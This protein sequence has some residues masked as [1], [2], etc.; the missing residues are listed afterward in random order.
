MKILLIG[1]SIITLIVFETGITY[2][3]PSMVIYASGLV[4]PIGI[5]ADNSGNL[6]VAEQGTGSG[7]TSR[8]S[9]VTTEKQVYPFLIDLPSS[10]PSFEPIG[11]EH[12][13]FDINGNVLVAQGTGSDSLSNSVLVVDT[14]GFIIGGPPLTRNSI[15]SKVNIGALVDFSNPYRIVLGPNDD[16]YVSDAGANRIFRIDRNTGVPSIFSIFN[17]IGQ[18]E[19]VP[20]GIVYTGTNFYVGI[21]TGLPI[22][23]GAAKIYN[24]DL[25]GNNSIY[26]DGFTAIV[27][28]A[29]NPVDNSL[30]ALQH[31]EFGPPWL[32]NKGRL[33]RIQDGIVDTLLSE[34]PRPSGMVF[35]TN[36]DLFITSLTGDNILKIT[37]IP[38]DVNDVN[39]IVP[40]DYLL[41]QNYPNPFNPS[42]KIS[43]N[44]SAGSFVA[45][46]V[47]DVLGNEVAVLVNEDKPAGSY[48]VDFNASGL[49]SGI[50]LY[51]LQSGNFAEIKKMM[52]LK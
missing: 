16:W 52:L 31:A 32:D 9:I 40:K 36:G 10:M 7:N 51:K 13:C 39:G 11:A 2:S 12:A 14:A 17:P 43:F 19:A 28:V 49:S 50:Y 22:P 20:T 29:I 34:L 3:Q 46:K 4:N 38:T 47:Y 25:S 33:F 35:N 23:I 41:K 37:N 8:I 18:I 48:E 6:W 45:L 1:F 26:Q 5:T 24:V 42:T 21:L 15:V 27:D 44:I 30:Y